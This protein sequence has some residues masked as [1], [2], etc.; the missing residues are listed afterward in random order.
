MRH[1]N[2]RIGV[3]GGNS[4]LRKELLREIEFLGWTGILFEANTPGSPEF[5]LQEEIPETFPW[6]ASAVDELEGLI[7]MEE[8]APKRWPRLG[9]A[10]GPDNRGFPLWNPRCQAS[11]AHVETLPAPHSFLLSH[12]FA[13]LPSSAIISA[14]L[15]SP[16]SAHGEGGMATMLE[17]AKSM[18]Q[19]RPPKGRRLAF[20]FSLSPQMASLRDL[21]QKEVGEWVPGSSTRLSLQGAHYGL[22]H[23]HSLF[24]SILGK[25]LPRVSRLKEALVLELTNYLPVKQ[26]SRAKWRAADAPQAQQVL[27][28]GEDD[29]PSRWIG[30]AWDDPWATAHLAMHWLHTHFQN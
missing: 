29:G 19:F 13:A 15:F 14:S 21:C 16:A 17:E 25:G 24:C 3:V 11:S 26:V 28:N 2:P 30:M 20:D 1:V 7:W 27:V 18:L 23:G 4:L 10:L 5:N 8:G 9:L 22:F 6:R 12:L